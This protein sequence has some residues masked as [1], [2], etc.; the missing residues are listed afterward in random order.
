MLFEKFT[1]LSR[2]NEA[3]RFWLELPLWRS[4]PKKGNVN[5][6]PILGNQNAS[7]VLILRTENAGCVSILRNGNT[8]SPISNWLNIFIYS[9][10]SVSL[11]QILYIVLIK[12]IVTPIRSRSSI[13][14]A[15]RL[16]VSTYINYTKKSNKW[17]KQILSGFF[18]N[19]SYTRI[20]FIRE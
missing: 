14:F 1:I 7:C 17:I 11:V 16:I 2:C 15:G 18:I 8:G 5:S 13:F 20:I 9:K 3:H 10:T 12:T 19:Y 6:V 4:V